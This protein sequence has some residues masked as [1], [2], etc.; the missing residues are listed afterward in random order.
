MSQFSTTHRRSTFAAVLSVLFVFLFLSPTT[1]AAIPIAEYQQNIKA[2]IAGLD[3]LN[4]LYVTESEDDLDTQLTQTI[5]NVRKALPKHQAVEF[6]G[7]VC[8]VDNSWLHRNLDEL[9]QAD[10]PSERLAQIIRELQA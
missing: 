3:H 8:N 4:F 6:E 10:D 2:A 7:D 9:E 1:V 5:E